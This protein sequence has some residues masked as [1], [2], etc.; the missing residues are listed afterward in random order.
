MTLSNTPLQFG[1]VYQLHN[2]SDDNFT[3]NRMTQETRQTVY[4]IT[5]DKGFTRSAYHPYIMV[6]D[7][8]DTFLMTNQQ[9]RDVAYVKQTAVRQ[10]AEAALE[11]VEFAKTQER[12]VSV[13][14]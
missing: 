7:G 11:V 4:S 9:E 1:A 2:T 13:E 10:Q 8:E 12:I 14:L 3:G 6:Q 5:R